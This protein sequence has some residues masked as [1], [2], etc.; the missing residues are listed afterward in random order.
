MKLQHKAWALVLVTV[1]FLTL[2]A[3]LVAEQAISSSFSKLEAER[4]ALEGERGR[5][6]LDQEMQ[7]LTATLKDYAYW[8]ET[9]QYIEGEKPEFLGENFTTDNMGSLHMTQ[10]LMLDLQGRPVGSVELTTESGLKPLPQERIRTFVELAA[11]V[12]ADASG[13][14]VLQT[15][16]VD[17]GDLVLIS[18]VSARVNST[19]GTPAKGAVVMAR[20]FDQSELVRFSDILM[21]PVRLSFEDLDHHGNGGVHMVV[22]NEHQVE[23]HAPVRDASGHSIADLIL[24]MQ[25]D[26]NAEGQ[27][28]KWAAGGGVAV[29]GLLLGAAL[30]LLLNRLLLRR[31]QRLHRDLEALSDNEVLGDALVQV[32]GNDELTTVARGIN[33][34]LLRVRQDA[35]EQRAA[36]ARQESL[37]QQLWQSQKVEALGRFTGGIAHDFNNSLAA[38]SGWMRLADEDLDRAHPSHEALQQALKAT[39]YADGLMRQ[40]LAFSRQAAPRLE[41]LSLCQLVEDSRGLV[42][43]GLTRRTTLEVAC[44][45]EAGWVQADRTQMQQVLVNLLMNASDA[46]NGEG[47]VRLT[48]DAVELPIA[49]DQPAMPEAIALPP[50]RY[51]CL[52]V[53]DQGPGI[54]PENLDRVFDPFFTTKSV[55]RGT[56]L[57]LSVVHGILARHGGAI[58]VRSALGE[59][60][61]FSILLPVCHQAVASGPAEVPGTS[62]AVRNM[63]FVDD[64][65]LVRHAWGTLL[66]RKGWAVTRARDGEEGWEIFSRRETRWDIVLTDLAMPKLDGQGLARRIRGTEAPPPIVLMSGNVSA[67]DAALL[68]KGDFAAV[69][70]KPVEAAELDRVLQQALKPAEMAASA[71]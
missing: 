32:E 71:A 70:H 66:E 40:L 21:Q 6:L 3:V 39:R 5:R 55:G 18:I 51:I 48:V 7:A 8:S 25:R 31:L 33:R 38:I 54:A 41:R 12:L 4:A 27:S 1:G 67:D 15:Y 14:S 28:L 35:E 65:Q 26:L 42:A 20:R 64:D 59:G 58:G 60:A 52:T 24:T 30:V 23:S 16:K 69:L 22:V 49:S 46:M 43:S 34:L 37:Q 62:P 13:E 2:A 61:A 63:L 68:M 56:G 44:T 11:P 29:A 50:G 45:S 53:Q 10:V 9:V 36:N 47:V 19:P 57:G 17:R